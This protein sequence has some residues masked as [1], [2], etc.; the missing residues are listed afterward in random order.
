M[1]LEERREVCVTTF[2]EHRRE[3]FPTD[4][5]ILEM[6]LLNSGYNLFTLISEN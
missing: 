4:S 3:C 1:G 6:S 2:K 5:Q